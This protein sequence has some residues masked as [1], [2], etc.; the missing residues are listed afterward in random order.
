[1]RGRSVNRECDRGGR[2]EEEKNDDEE[3]DDEEEDERGRTRKNEEER[4]WSHHGMKEDSSVIQRKTR[5]DGCELFM[6]SLGGHRDG[7]KDDS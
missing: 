5:G 7:D 1:M 6:G 2:E 3:E 4:G